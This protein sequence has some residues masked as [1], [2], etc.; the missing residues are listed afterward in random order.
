MDDMASQNSESNAA[1]TTA[2][3]DKNCPFCGQAFTSSSLGRHLDLYIK[4]N[5]PKPSDGVH[6]V[7]AIKKLR[8]GIT[9][10]QARASGATRKDSTSS[11]R[12]RLSTK[13]EASS[14][15]GRS[16]AV[17]STPRGADNAAED[18]ADNA[19]NSASI[20]HP[21]VSHWD[22]ADAVD[23]V[24][25]RGPGMPRNASK[26]ATQKTQLE[27]RQ[28]LTDAMDKARAAE[29]ALREIVGS[30]WAAKQD[31]KHHLMP[32]D[33]D[34]LA[35]DF[36]ALSLQCLQ[37]PPTL[38]SSTQYPTPTSWSVQS[39]GQREYNALQAFFEEGFKLWRMRRA[40]VFTAGGEEANHT[41]SSNFPK[42]SRETIK[43]AEKT[44]RDL[45]SSFREHLQ[46]AY[47][48]WESLPTQKRQEI[49]ILELARG[50][51]R[52]HAE[53]ENMKELQQ[54]LMQENGHL[55]LQIDQLNRLQQP[56]ELQLLS[57][58]TAP[59]DRDVV[60]R[61]NEQGVEGAKCEAM[62]G[63]DR[64]VGIS[65][66]VTRSI[67]RWRSVI[68][69]TRV[70]SNGATAQSSISQPFQ[71]QSSHHGSSRNLPQ[72]VSREGREKKQQKQQQK[73]QQQ[74]QQHQHQQHHQQQQQPPKQQS[75]QQQR[76]HR[77]GSQQR[78][79]NGKRPSIVRAAAPVSEC[80]ASSTHTTGPPSVEDDQDADAEMEDDDNFAMINT[81]C[82]KQPLASMHLST[83]L[84]VPRP[85]ALVQ[86]QASTPDMRLMMQGDLGSPI[87]G[88]SIMV[89]NRP[90]PNMNM[91]ME[92]RHM[93]GGD[94]TLMQQVRGDALYMDNGM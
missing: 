81:S 82:V 93:Q 41:P 55:K 46:S 19:A 40:S 80:S 1:K 3:K 9:R 8:G 86:Q 6:D 57:S 60:S 73:Q 85:Q 10:R 26:E 79:L 31:L 74:Q 2:P 71:M 38:F 23:G 20:E 53:I 44:A 62:D 28:E 69:S 30:W 43:R 35:L 54:R 78:N 63:T 92:E 34:P 65:T 7:E 27:L 58:T 66:L 88:G 87:I 70:A 61:A 67:E 13:R 16:A 22:T 37:P 18:A 17:K 32:F 42:D 51:G 50:V 11:R 15:K 25:A 84:D 52:K 56:P 72:S 76:R 47:V 24:S 68:A 94:M 36:P 29:L 89:M 33:F 21:V 75:Q 12:P 77:P 49:W 59:V 14:Q 4:E 45:E 90:M 64:H 39:P 83:G 91:A 48:V 5:N